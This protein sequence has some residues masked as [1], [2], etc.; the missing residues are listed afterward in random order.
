MKIKVYVV[1]YIYL[2]ILFSIIFLSFTASFESFAWVYNTKCSFN[3]ITKL[4]CPSCGLTRSFISMSS[5]NFID[6]FNY[7]FIGIGLYF[8]FCVELF[9][10]LIYLIYNKIILQFKYRLASFY[11]LIVIATLRW[12]VLI[13]DS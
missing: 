10:G 13:I 7:N 8:L 11:F 6:A 4:P 5:G 1:Y 12:I 2:L 9:I 3:E